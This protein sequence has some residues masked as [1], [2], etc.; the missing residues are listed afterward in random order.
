MGLIFSVNVGS[1]RIIDWHGQQVSTAIWKFPVA[2]PRRLAGVNVDGDEQAD[3]SVHGG[4]DKAVYAY[5]RE[6]LEFFETLHTPITPGMFGENLTTLG[7]SI[8]DAVIGERWQVG[9]ALLQVA[10][11]RLPCFKLGIRMND[12]LFPRR[13]AAAGRPGTYLRIL[14]EGDVGPGDKVAI[15]DRPAHGIT[16]GQVAHIY[17]RDR[18]AAGRLLHAP[19]LP[20]EWHEWAAARQAILPIPRSSPPQTGTARV[21][22]R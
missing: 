16:V 7:L 9:S 4:A 6:D 18:T 19:E 5:A 15:V 21:K 22:G 17:H 8:T 12:P 13:F 2:G 11:P 20:T 3:R 14:T 1:P 10:Q